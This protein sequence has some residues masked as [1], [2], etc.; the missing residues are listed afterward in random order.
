MSF[1]LE[2]YRP[3]KF[4]D[5][6]GNHYALQ[7]GLDWIAKFKSGSL[8]KN[9]KG[10]L[11]IGPPGVGKTSF[12]RILLTNQGFEAME[13]NASNMRSK[14]I[15]KSMLDKVVYG[16]NI[17]SMMN[18]VPKQIGIVMDEVDGC[19]TGDFGGIKEIVNYLKLDAK[20]ESKLKK[21]KKKKSF[22]EKKGHNWNNILIPLKNP[23]ICISNTDNKKIV[24]IKRCSEVIYFKHPSEFI[25]K[26]YIEDICKKEKLKIPTYG[27]HLIYEKSQNDFRRILMMVDILMT[28]FVGKTN[29]TSNQVKNAINLLQ[30]KNVDLTLNNS[31]VE[32]F[33]NIHSEDKFN[34]DNIDK[35]IQ[36]DVI[37]IPLLIYEN[38]FNFMLNN[39]EGSIQQKA[40]QISKYLDSV[41]TYCFFENKLY[42]DKLWG[43]SNY[44]IST[45]CIGLHTSLRSLKKKIGTPFEINFTRVLSKNS[46]KFN[47]IRYNELLSKKL[48]IDGNKL[49]FFSNIFFSE[50]CKIEK[51]LKKKEKKKEKK[52]KINNEKECNKKESNK[53][54]RINNEKESNKKECN[55]KESNKK[56]RI[57]NEKAEK[58]KKLSKK[59]KKE[60]K[61]NLMFEGSD[62]FEF[63]RNNNL[64][65]KDLD[66]ICKLSGNHKYWSNKSIIEEFIDTF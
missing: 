48:K 26:K 21:K 24:E 28:N 38:Y 62:I 53:N 58:K 19:I 45:C 32:I 36:C 10:L 40:T 52:G 1:I 20:L 16:N 41:F 17:I 22:N 60:E 11:I 44:M 9:K 65:K 37:L 29:V 59:K 39:V 7:K 13:L 61:I 33:N 5:I 63:V 31:V 55:K 54:E 66:K 2:K 27:I 46:V 57:N 12:A 14:K 6:Q 34:V 51:D 8:P 64:E 15:I 23:I 47:Y 35:Y 3:K 56:E 18:Q 50:I 4:S 43:M 25:M 49:S 30:K 42:F